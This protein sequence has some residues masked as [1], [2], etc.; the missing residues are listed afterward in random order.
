MTEDQ[1]ANLWAFARGDTAGHEFEQW[2]LAQEDLEGPLGEGLHWSLAS[3]AY[4]DRDEVWKLRQSVAQKLEPHKQCECASIRDLA[5]IPMGC[6]GLDERVFATVENVRDHGGDLW[7]LH[8]SKCRVCGQNWMVAQEERIFDDY[9]LRRLS[10]SEAREISDEGRWPAEFLTYERIL[11]IGRTLSQPCIFADALSPSV[12]WTVEDLRSERPDITADEI[13][14][15]LGV[16][17][18]NIRRLLA[19]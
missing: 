3:A 7:W 15:L 14:Y 12:V 4:A 19:A 6:D 13:A 8:L 16:T 9:F 17:P 5:A 11:M 2:F 18:E 10:V 1:F